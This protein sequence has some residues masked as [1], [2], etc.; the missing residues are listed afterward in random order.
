MDLAVS[1]ITFDST[2]PVTISFYVNDKLLDKVRYAEPGNKHFEK[3]VPPDWLATDRM[4]TM[5]AEIDKMYVSPEDG[6]K[7]G[8]ILSRAG[9]AE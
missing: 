3:D 4:N 9:F 6:T 5:A 7:L 2:G 1:K 8:F